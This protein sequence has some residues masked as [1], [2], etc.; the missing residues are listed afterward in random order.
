MRL[1][2]LEWA[3]AL[4]VGCYAALAGRCWLLPRWLGTVR[5]TIQAGTD[6][7]ARWRRIVDGLAAAGDNRAA[8]LQLAEE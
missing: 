1:T 3:E 8:Q 2:G 5:S 6:S 4:T 7:T